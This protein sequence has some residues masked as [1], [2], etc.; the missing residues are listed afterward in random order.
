MLN[1]TVIVDIF[2]K[3]WYNTINL[4]YV[5]N[6]INLRRAVRLNNKR[7]GGKMKKRIGILTSGGDCPG[8]NATIRGVAKACYEMMGE[9]NVKS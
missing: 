3:N 6:K 4:L 9:D 1:Q 2:N 7:L 8:L 5:F